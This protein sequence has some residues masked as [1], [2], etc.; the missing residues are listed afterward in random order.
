MIGVLQI[1][2]Q[3]LGG[4]AFALLAPAAIALSSEE[5]IAEGFLVVAGLVGFLAGALFFA[6]HGR[7]GNL[8]RGH[9]LVIALSMW[10]AVP[11]IAAVP[12]MLSTGLDYV[13]S[14]FE[15]ASGFT[16]TGA[17][18]F[19]SLAGVDPAVIF[20]RAELQWLGGLV[21]LCTCVLVLAP[22]ALGGLSSR[23]LA[24]I[25]GFTEAGSSRAGLVI[26]EVAVL[27]TTMTGLCIV[28]LFVGGV[29]TFDAICLAFSTISTGGFMPIDGALTDYGS[30]FAEFVVPV[31]M[32]VG[33]S[34]IVWQRMVLEGRRAML[35]EHR[36]TYWVVG[37]ALAVGVVYAIQ[38][39]GLEALPEALGEG[40]FT[41][42][43]L[44]STTGFETRPAGLAALPDSL[45]L[46]LALA[47]AASLSTAGGVKFYR[48]GGMLVQSAHELKRLIF[49]HSVRSHRFGSQPYDLGL[50]KAIWAN[51]GLS[52]VVIAAA[53]LILSLSLPTFDAAFIATVAAFSSVGPLYTADWPM[54]VGW[55]AYGALDGLSK[56]TLVAIMILG[57]LEVIAFFAAINVAYW[58]S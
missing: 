7:R 5:G 33:A 26:R 44:V 24:L 28:L 30:R 40:L 25:G 2:A 36:E 47:G 18:V 50:M 3:V 8:R 29:P 12:I 45:V 19:A 14:L 27:Y 37:V 52:L 9:R 31:F 57:R 38:F 41:G 34:S 56:V 48:V 11:V 35:A 17:T 1:L 22:A 6:L 15:A 4:L 32:L 49:P 42:I 10:I 16:T 21:T 55:P 46:I 54:S 13:E 20:W 51:L 23:G 58:R 43:S 53:A 39:A